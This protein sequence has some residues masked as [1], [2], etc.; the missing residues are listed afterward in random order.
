MLQRDLRLVIHSK[1]MNLLTLTEIRRAVQNGPVSA[2]VH[3]QV[4]SVTGK[5]QREGKP[6]CELVLADACDRIKLR[7]WS[8]HPAYKT[9]SEF[10]TES[11]IQLEGEFYQ[12]PQYG[13]EVEKN[14][15]TVRPLT[16]QEKNE[17][18]QGPADL[19][20]KQAA[21]FE[22]LRQTVIAIADPRLRALSEAFLD[23]W[24][25]RFRRTAAARNYH[26]ARRGG[27]VEHTAQM[28]RVAKQ[29]A[30]LYPELNLDLLLAG[31]LFHDSGKLWE[32]ALPENGFVMNYDELGELMGHI[33]IGLELVNALWRRLSFE[34]A[35]AWKNLAPASEDVRMHLLHLIGAHHGEP[36]FGSPVAPK[37]PEAMALHYI[38]NLD[39]RLEMFAAGYTTA[40]PLAARIFDRV[41]PLPGN[42]V[43]SLEKFQ[44]APSPPAPRDKLL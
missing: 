33:S 35:E 15:W 14:R 44:Q 9:C 24:G 11:F 20:T 8:D 25:D 3:V 23:E 21:D 30:P 26:H 1:P 4:E 13:L 42:L 40:K 41:R 22:F 37:T 19:R 31:I 6:Y 12:H 17:L 29:I 18:L 32:N 43:K 16:E 38:D 27:L 7:V 34:N 5:T 36:E 10:T 2:R 28:M 39:A